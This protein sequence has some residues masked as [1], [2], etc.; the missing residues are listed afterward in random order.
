MSV[1]SPHG[2]VYSIRLYVKKF[3]IKMR[4]V[5]S[6]LWVLRFLP[7]IKLTATIYSWNIVESGVKHYNPN[8]FWSS[9]LLIIQNSKFQHG[10]Y[11]FCCKLR[12]WKSSL[13]SHVFLDCYRYYHLHSFYTPISRRALLC[14]WVLRASRVVSAR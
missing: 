9:K 2:K 11:Y 13:R 4:Q 10:C 3:V 12:I 5:S 8:P 14:D 7:P 1:N 6:F